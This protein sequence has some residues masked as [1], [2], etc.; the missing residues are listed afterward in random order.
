MD[1]LNSNAKADP[2]GISFKG[3]EKFRIDDKPAKFISC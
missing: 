2:Y 3:H 1:F